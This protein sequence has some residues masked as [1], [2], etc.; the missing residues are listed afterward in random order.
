M[1]AG[2]NLAGIHS[3]P[4]ISIFDFDL[5][6]F[7]A[8]ATTRFPFVLVHQRDV[9]HTARTLISIHGAGGLVQ[10]Y[11][12]P[13]NAGYEF[14]IALFTLNPCVCGDCTCGRMVRIARFCSRQ[15]SLRFC[16]RSRCETTYLIR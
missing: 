1:K 5:Y 11:V 12:L 2:E 10:V 6:L 3:T 9:H 13:T 8:D 14:A 4:L 7:C 15:T 16:T